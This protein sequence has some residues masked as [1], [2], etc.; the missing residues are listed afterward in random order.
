LAIDNWQKDIERI[1]VTYTRQTIKHRLIRKDIFYNSFFMG[2]T[3]KVQGPVSTGLFLWLRASK[4][5]RRKRG[6]R[7]F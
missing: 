3:F 7:R 5:K 2:V 6:E 1:I 4:S